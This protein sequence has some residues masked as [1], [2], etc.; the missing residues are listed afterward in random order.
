MNSVTIK[1]E[2]INGHS[3]DETTVDISKMYEEITGKKYNESDPDI[4]K[5]TDSFLKEIT[6]VM[7]RFYPSEYIY[8]SLIYHKGDEDVTYINTFPQTEQNNG[9]PR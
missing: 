4:D 3:S 8:K 9:Q 2:A 1:L 5:I 7:N 6:D